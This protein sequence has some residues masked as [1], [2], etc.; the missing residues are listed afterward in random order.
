MDSISL[1]TGGG[2]GG[3]G[4][5]FY[6]PGGGFMVLVEVVASLHCDKD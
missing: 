4:G 6:D 5:F 3:S 1:P 2:V